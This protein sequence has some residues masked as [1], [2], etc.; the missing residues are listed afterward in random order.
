M[1][2]VS[3]VKWRPMS[4]APKDSQGVLVYVPGQANNLQTLGLYV[5][6]WSAWGG[7]VWEATT[8]W[9][10]FKDELHGTVWTELEPIAA[11]AKSAATGIVE[12]QD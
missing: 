12:P 2:L 10:P 11:S 5:M 9:R 4:E 8:G 1:I 7:G 6:R 3:T